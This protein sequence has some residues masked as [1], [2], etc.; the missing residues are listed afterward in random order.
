MLPSPHLALRLTRHLCK[1]EH[2]RRRMFLRDDT[3]LQSQDTH[4]DSEEQAEA[5]GVSS[6]ILWRWGWVICMI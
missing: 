3:K 1:I 6:Q 5:I 4:V 2:F